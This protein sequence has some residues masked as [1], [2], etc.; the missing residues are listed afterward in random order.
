MIAHTEN[1]PLSTSKHVKRCK[2]EIFE[3]QPLE[4]VCNS[5]A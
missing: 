4:K 2:Y 3:P 5:I 1:Y